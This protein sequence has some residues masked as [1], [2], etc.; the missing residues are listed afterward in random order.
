VKSLETI[1]WISAYCLHS[2]ADG[3]EPE[4]G[5]IE[6]SL[7]GLEEGL[8]FQATP[9]HSPRDV[10]TKTGKQNGQKFDDQLHCNDFKLASFTIWRTEEKIRLTRVV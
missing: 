10:I 8:P 6:C 3:K 2:S 4:D 5:C 1:S 7:F 9:P